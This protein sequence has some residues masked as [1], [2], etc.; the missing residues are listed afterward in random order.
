MSTARTLTIVLLL[1]VN[2]AALIYLHNA[3]AKRSYGIVLAE[4]TATL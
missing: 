4:Q 1:I 2:I 3:E